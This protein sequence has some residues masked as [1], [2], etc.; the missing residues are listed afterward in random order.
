MK[1]I[2]TGFGQMAGAKNDFLA[3]HF[4]KIWF[5]TSDF[6]WKRSHCAPQAL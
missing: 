2:S 4:P 3:I 5:E 6:S 1:G